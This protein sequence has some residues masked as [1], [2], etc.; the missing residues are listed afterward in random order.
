MIFWPVVPESA[1]R[2]A[3]VSTLPLSAG[4]QG[5]TSLGS[6]TY[7]IAVPYLA[8]KII[9]DAFD[10]DIATKNV[11]GP[12]KVDASGNVKVESARQ[13]V[14]AK[15]YSV[16]IH[17]TDDAQGDIIV[18]DKYSSSVRNF[19]QNLRVTTKGQANFYRNS[20]N[21]GGVAQIFTKKGRIVAIEGP[22]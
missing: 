4:P 2:L 15:G 19:A 8:L 12:Q 21:K 16:E 3:S 6:I 1:A 9:L 22:F 14:D 10:G 17:Q 5:K 13:S 18:K 11:F 7:R 20:R